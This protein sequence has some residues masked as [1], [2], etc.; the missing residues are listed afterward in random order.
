[1]DDNVLSAAVEGRGLESICR[2]FGCKETGG[3]IRVLFPLPFGF[4]RVSPRPGIVPSRRDR[5]ESRTRKNFEFI[6]IVLFLLPTPTEM[7]KVWF[8]VRGL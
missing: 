1:M 7:R 5:T 6:T 2:S 4:Y 3:C 8:S